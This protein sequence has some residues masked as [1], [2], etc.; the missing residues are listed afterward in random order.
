M[1]R[2][3]FQDNKHSVQLYAPIS[4]FKLMI[5]FILR[6]YIRYLFEKFEC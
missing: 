2:G 4:E 5:V 1:L 6:E 3:K